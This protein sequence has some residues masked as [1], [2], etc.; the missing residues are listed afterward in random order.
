MFECWV[1]TTAPSI[2]RVPAGDGPASWVSAPHRKPQ[3]QRPRQ[4]SHSAHAHPVYEWPSQDS[5]PAML[6]A[7]ESLPPH[8]S[9]P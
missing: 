3:P 4:G 1:G 9:L 8:T 2:Q 6:A 5:A 7:L